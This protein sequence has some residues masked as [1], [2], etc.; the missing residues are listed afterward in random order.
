[1][2]Y[3]RIKMYLEHYLIFPTFLSNLKKQIIRFGLSIPTSDQIIG[4]TKL[5]QTYD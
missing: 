2:N 4:V 3:I 5:Y 1:M